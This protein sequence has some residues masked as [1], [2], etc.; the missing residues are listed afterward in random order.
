MTKRSQ[1]YL[2]RHTPTHPDCG[3]VTPKPTDYSGTGV[4]CAR[5]AVV[6]CQGFAQLAE[7]RS[8]GA[9]AIQLFLFWPL[10]LESIQAAT[11]LWRTRLLC[12]ALLARARVIDTSCGNCWSNTKRDSPVSFVGILVECG[13]HE[14]AQR[15]CEWRPRAYLRTIYLLRIIL[16][17]DTVS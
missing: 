8:D 7:R 10:T 17:G 3:L 5:K 1:L 4:W 12:N 2:T 11:M 6:H 9:V 13:K 14:T 15:A 16:W